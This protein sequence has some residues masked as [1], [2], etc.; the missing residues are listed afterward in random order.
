MSMAR[1]VLIVGSNRA[2]AL[3]SSYARAFHK[4]GWQVHFWDPMQALRR[5]ARG[6]RLGALFSTF[7]HVEPWLN[8]ANLDLL[9][10][11]QKM[12]PDLMLVV[13]TGGVRAGTLAQLRVLVPHM[14]LY[15]VYP[16]SPHNLDGDRIHCLPFFERVTTSSP[17]WVQA[18][19]RLGASRVHYLPFAADTELHR[20]D[21]AGEALPDLA[22]AVAFIGTWRA[23]R[24][25][26]LEQLA[27]FDLRVWG[28]DYWK[29]RT[30]PGS[31]LR[32][33]WGGRPLVGAEF[34]QACA[35]SQVMLN[36]MDP[37]T[38]PGPNMRTFELP[39]CQAFALVERSPAVLDLFCEG[40]TIECFA[41]VEEARDKI[42]YY[43]DHEAARQR[44]AQAGYRFVVEA[45][46]TY[47]DRARQVLTWAIED[48]AHG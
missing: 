23:E 5:V 41:S 47:V 29:R 31:S 26:L 40:E 45:G 1:I 3:E 22:H 25:A 39:A 36:V 4:L 33:C 19:E 48:G 15:C 10:L 35:R 11:A 8:K 46:H 42:R 44:I 7:V 16:D 21:A 34:A 37:V 2:E 13:G 6:G 20:P 18:F 24:E 14:P 12:R 27:D 9:G 17:A 30:R 28:N 43:L 32:A 38:W